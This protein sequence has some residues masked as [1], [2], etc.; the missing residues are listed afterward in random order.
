MVDQYSNEV[1]VADRSMYE[2]ALHFEF[3]GGSDFLAYEC[4]NGNGTN[5]VVCPIRAH[6]VGT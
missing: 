5:I 4:A 1:P 6:S 2:T 3:E